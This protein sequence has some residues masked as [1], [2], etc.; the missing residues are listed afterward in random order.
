LALSFSTLITL[1]TTLFF[2]VKLPLK[3]PGGLDSLIGKAREDSNF[4]G[5]FVFELNALINDS[6]PLSDNSVTGL[7]DP[8]AASSTN[9]FTRIYLF[10]ASCFLIFAISFDSVLE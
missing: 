7:F 4:F 3:L 5:V 10:I 8:A 6:Y 9:A 2:H 1:C